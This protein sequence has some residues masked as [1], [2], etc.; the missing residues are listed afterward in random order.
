MTDN[1]LLERAYMYLNLTY[2]RDFNDQRVING[3]IR[4]LGEHLHLNS[5]DFKG[6]ENQ[7]TITNKRGK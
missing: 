1:E 4:E 7:T 5:N 2:T 6:R 3:F